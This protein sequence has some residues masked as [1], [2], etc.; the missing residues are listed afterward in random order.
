[1]P[2]SSKYIIDHVFTKSAE[3]NERTTLR[4]T[5]VENDDI[6]PNFFSDDII[7]VKAFVGK[8]GTG[9]TILLEEH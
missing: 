6:P 8:N 4:I 9:K 5:V 3:N 1:M 7:D 2:L